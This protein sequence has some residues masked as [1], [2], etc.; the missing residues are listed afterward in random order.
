MRAPA[1]VAGMLRHRL[2]VETPRTAA[3]G[4]VTWTVA[5]TVWAAIDPVSAGERE[6]GAHLEGTATHRITLRRRAGLT[7]VDRLT[8]GGRR[9]RIL[10]ILDPD[11]AGRFLTILV[12]EEG[13]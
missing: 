12:E 8:R 5:G 1:A 7:S 6:R 10:G 11:E 9:F 13:R 3:N 4:D 2:R